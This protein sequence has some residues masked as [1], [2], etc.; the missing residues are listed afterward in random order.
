MGEYKSAS[1]KTG[2][3]QIVA[4]TAHLHTEN[5]KNVV[6]SGYRPFSI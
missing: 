6:L 4:V 3:F 5:I 1:T 2:T